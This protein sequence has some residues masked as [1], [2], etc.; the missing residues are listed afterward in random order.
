MSVISALAAAIAGVVKAKRSADKD[1]KDAKGTA[2]ID[3]LFKL[4]NVYLHW[5]SIDPYMTNS[6]KEKL[7]SGFEATIMDLQNR[8]TAISARTNDTTLIDLSLEL[9]L[10]DCVQEL[11][12]KYNHYKGAFQTKSIGVKKYIYNSLVIT[13]DDTKPLLAN[14]D[15]AFNVG[16]ERCR[17]DHTLN[18]DSKRGVSPAYQLRSCETTRRYVLDNLRDPELS[19]VLSPPVVEWLEE[20]RDSYQVSS[21]GAHCTLCPSSR[22]I[23]SRMRTSCCWRWC[24]GSATSTRLPPLW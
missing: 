6:D 20:L 17:V 3:G 23:W 8:F 24:S 1:T 10:A 21:T 12:T 16:T 7:G 2:S 5:I 19:F 18:L 11:L 15:D 9:E 22:R 13:I 14:A 4:L